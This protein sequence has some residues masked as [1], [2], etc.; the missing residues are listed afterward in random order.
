MKRKMLLVCL[1]S[2]GMVQGIEPQDEETYKQGYSH[3][4]EQNWDGAIEL[5]TRFLKEH[6]DSSWNDDASFWICYSRSRK[7]QSKA[8]AFQC[9]RDFLKSYP[10]SNWSDDAYDHMAK[11]ADQ[12]DEEGRPEFRKMLRE[13][14]ETDN[15]EIDADQKALLKILASLGDI[16]DASSVEV[17]LGHLDDPDPKFRER[18]VRILED[19][20][21]PKVTQKLIGLIDSDP[22]ERVR[23]M[24]IET[25]GE[26]DANPD[27]DR[28]LIR[29]AKQEDAPEMLRIS[30]VEALEDRELPGLEL[31]FR[32]VAQTARRF[33]VKE[34]AIEALGDLESE[35]AV[36]VLME[37]FNS[38]E[39]EELRHEILDSLG[40][41]EHPKAFEFISQLA[42]DGEDS[43]LT[44]EAIENLDE[45]EEEKAL[46]TL[47]QIIGST[48]HWRNKAVA[49]HTLA[50]FE[51]T[52][53]RSELE[54]ILDMDVPTAV[55]IV[56]IEG[57][58][59]REDD[60]EIVS[61]LNRIYHKYDEPVL[62]EAA[63]EALGDLGTEQ[64]RE[65]LL[66][67]LK[68][69]MAARKE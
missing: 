19:V 6:P 68:E 55:K 25:I 61:V 66:T 26:L 7:S 21:H 16:G 49:V 48:S 32:E 15:E 36:T 47:K 13:L 63:V 42:M 39:S 53:I 29:Y 10:S 65:A 5:F 35:G 56:A 22:S 37:L 43:E 59:Y 28:L 12:L 33:G 64:A 38:I 17:I 51:G 57:L 31:I 60:P 62:Q 50:D 20:E 3:V 40:D 1:F 44:R 41:T 54:S 18:L 11:L 14:Y 4:L 2:W 30:A 8:D 69:K 45:F 9:F 23:A 27:I 46:A 58:G 34:A 67:I 52:S 24:A